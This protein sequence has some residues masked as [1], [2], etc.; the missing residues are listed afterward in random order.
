MTFLPILI[1]FMALV[2]MELADDRMPLLIGATEI[3]YCRPALGPVE[4]AV[5]VDCQR[6][7]ER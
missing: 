1:H 2:P 4:P 7:D 5:A 3:P 6:R